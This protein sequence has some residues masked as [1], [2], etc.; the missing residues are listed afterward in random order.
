MKNIYFLLPS[1]IALAM[2]VSSCDPKDTPNFETEN[3]VSEFVYDGMSTYY[4]WA[5][6]VE[7]KK[8]TANDS[9]PE[10][11]FYKILNSTDTEHGWS[12][13]TDDVD[14]L[15]A[16]FEGEETNAFGFQP[17]ALWSDQSYTSL[18]GFIR[19]VYP[20]T[21]AQAAGLKRGE[22][23]IKIDN[24]TITEN[25][26]LKMFGANTQTTFTV[27]DQNFE[28]QRDVS[29]TPASF[30]TD[31][32]LFSGIY[33]ISGSKIGYL[34][35]TGFI[36]KYNNSLFNA[37]STFKTA[38]ITDLVLDLRYNP[39]GGIDAAVYLASLVAPES[40]V[41]EKDVFS[42]MSYNT[43]LN[44]VFDSNKWDR[45]TYLGMYDNDIYHDPLEAN[46]NLNKVYVITTSSS[47]SASELLTFCLK[48]YMTV[49]QIGEKT[50][51]KYTASWTLHAYNSYENRVQPIYKES[52]LSTSE[53]NT[54][55]NWAMQPIVGKYTDK[56]NHDF[57]AT[58]GL[59]PDNIVVSQEYN[60]ES[61]KPIGDVD[62]YLFAKAISLITKTPLKS[63]HR[64]I[65]A[66]PFIDP[67]LYSPIEK[68][69]RRGVIDSPKII[70][71]E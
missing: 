35:Y 31:P 26:Y 51:G 55:K 28:N 54:L 40:F 61:W 22:V 24:E 5:D 23:I 50:S 37:F 60:T 1:F 68:V 2:I 19:Y 36:S 42:I 45:N 63:T 67:G 58:N 52:N 34:F 71:V 47:A 6:E 46:L 10:A 64:S 20:N 14:A 3:I 33:E 69:L 53:K 70:P 25:N 65:E 59:I 57:I 16:G 41:K 56:N 27:L 12:W 15:L 49:E 48:P 7:N 9:D 21:P 29:I 11:Y 18:L 13:I 66:T 30:N 62:D 17:L 4:L 39:G 44:D 32:V 8:P 38:G 43:Y